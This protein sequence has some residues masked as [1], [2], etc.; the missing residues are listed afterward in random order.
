M[1]YLLIIDG[2][3]IDL[4][5]HEVYCL[6]EEQLVD[7]LDARA[8]WMEDIAYEHHT[9]NLEAIIKKTLDG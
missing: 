3:V 2:V 8:D 7:V 9:S 1:R 6:D 4:N 5:D